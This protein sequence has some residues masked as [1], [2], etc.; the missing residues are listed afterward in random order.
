MSNSIIYLE[1]A[2]QLLK[3][4]KD[5]L[6]EQTIKEWN[7]SLNQKSENLENAINCL[8]DQIKRIMN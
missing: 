3:D 1:Y 6:D 4:E 2:V 7:E 5:Q 8:E